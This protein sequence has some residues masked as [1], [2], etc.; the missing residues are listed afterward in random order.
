MFSELRPDPHV[1]RSGPGRDGD[2][3]ARRSHAGAAARRAADPQRGKVHRTLCRS[4]TPASPCCAEFCSWIAVR[5]VSHPGLYSLI[6]VVVVAG[7]S[8]I[9]ASLEPRYRL[10][11]QVPDKQQAVEAS[12]RLDA[13]LTGANPIDVLIEFPE[14]RVAV[15]RRDAQDDCRRARHRREA[16]RCRQRVVGGIAAPL[17]RGKG[18]QERRRHAQ[19]IRR[20]AAR[21]SDA[22]FRVGRAGCGRRCRPHS[23][24][25]RQPASSGGRCAGQGAGDRA[26]RLIQAI[27][28]R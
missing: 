16:G 13:K 26:L 18:R 5:M 10:A 1:R 19:A 8:M 3:A 23:R 20:D 17:A 2:R 6:A 27:A 21:I 24:L 28:S 22:P 15:R 7:L 12:G 11:D 4:R 9:Y 14:G 25:R